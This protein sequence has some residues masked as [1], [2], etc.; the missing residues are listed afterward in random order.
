MGQFSSAIEEEL[1]VGKHSTVPH[2]DVMDAA[3]KQECITDAKKQEII[4]DAVTKSST[5]DTHD[6][7]RPT[8]GLQGWKLLFAV[9]SPAKWSLVLALLFTFL[10]VFMNVGL[11]TVSSLVSV[12]QYVV[13]LNVIHR[14]AWH[15]K[16][17]M[18]Y[19]YGSMHIWSH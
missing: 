7:N 5:L 10:T 4:T 18:V 14:I 9:L 6:V 8:M 3:Q 16:A 15:S 17:F 11:L 1:K 19:V 2:I 13:I 12:V